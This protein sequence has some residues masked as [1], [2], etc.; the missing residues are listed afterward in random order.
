MD[1]V[2]DSGVSFSARDAAAHK[3]IFDTRAAR[4]VQT[5]KRAE[6]WIAALSALVTVLTTAVVVKGPD[7]FTKA[8]GGAR[9]VVLA[10]ITVGMVGLGAGLVCAYTAAF[11]GL[12]GRGA[13][14][15]LV[16]N[17]PANT[18][19]AAVALERAA[20]RDAQTSR[21][22]MRV[23]LSAT[24]G[25]MVCLL[26]AVGVSWFAAPRPESGA[27]SQVCLQTTSGLVVISGPVTIKS[28]AVSFVDCPPIAAS[29]TSTTR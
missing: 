10:L 12:F 20:T 6:A 18:Q 16:D 8:G 14:D 22:F 3:L 24:V 11:G 1:R 5:R 25:A 2:G 21:R 23:A 17:P 19:G 27:G 9:G 28:G 15:T 13:L 7:T 29:V 4:L 26:S